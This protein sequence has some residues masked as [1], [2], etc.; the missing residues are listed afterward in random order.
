MTLTTQIWSAQ[1]GRVE[2]TLP[3]S[4]ALHRGREARASRCVRCPGEG[5]RERGA[6]KAVLVASAEWRKQRDRGPD[7]TAGGA[8]TDHRVN[9]RSSAP[10]DH[11]KSTRVLSYRRPLRRSRTDMR[12]PGCRLVGSAPCHPLSAAPP[13]LGPPSHARRRPRSPRPN[14]QPCPRWHLPGVGPD[15]SMDG[16]PGLDRHD[17][18]AVGRSRAGNRQRTHPAKKKPELIARGQRGVELGYHALLLRVVRDHRHLLLRRRLVHRTGELAEESSTLP[19]ESGRGPKPLTL[20]PTAHLDD[21]ETRRRSSS[22]SASPI[23]RG[24]TCPTTTLQ[25]SQVLRSPPTSSIHDARRLHTR[26]TTAPPPLS[27]PSPISAQRAATLDRRHPDRPRPTA[28]PAKLPTVAWINDPPTSFSSRVDPDDRRVDVQ[29]HRIAFHQDRGWTTLV[30]VTERPL[31]RHVHDPPTLIAA[32]V[33]ATV[34]S[35]AHHRTEPAR[36]GGVRYRG[37]IRR[38][39]RASTRCGPTPCPGHAPVSHGPGTAPRRKARHRGRQH[40]RTSRPRGVRHARR[41][42]FH[43][44]RS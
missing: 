29:Q 28:R 27:Y 13:K 37:T 18:P 39:R 4:A 35:D 16:A 19:P 9:G 34:V 22:T 31:R 32:R 7:D 12:P 26:H 44:T 8:G 41:P 36:R 23:T 40:Q 42:R 33:R 25:R 38:P 43:P 20:P 5:Q 1:N 21:L 24:L 2:T 3:R 17:V 6:A 30:A 10:R 15:S 14:G 11:G